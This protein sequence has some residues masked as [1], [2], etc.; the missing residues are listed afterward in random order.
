MN[1]AGINR[2]KFLNSSTRSVASAGA[3]AAVGGDLVRGLANC[4]G[5]DLPQV[6]FP[7]ATDGDLVHEPNWDQYLS[8]TVGPSV[9]SKQAD[10]V[11]NDDKVIQAAIDYVTRLGGGTVR[12]LPGEYILRSSV[13]LPTGLRLLGSGADS[14]LTKIGSQSIGLSEDSDWYDQEITLATDSDFRVGDSVVLRATDPHHGGPIVIKRRLIA[15]NGNR[16]KLNDGLRKNLWHSGK[17]TCASLF[18][19]LTSENVSDVV[20]ENLTLDGNRANNE[21]FNGNHGGC[22]FLQDCSRFVMKN[23]ETR[24]YNGDGISFQICHD[25]VVE[26]CHSHGNAGLGIHPGSGSQRPLIRNNRME[27]NQIGLFWCWGVKY[28]LGEGNQLDANQIGIS[29][30]HNDTDNLMRNNRVA[31]SSKVGIIFRD[32]S[33]GHNFW[34]NRNRLEKNEVIDSGGEEGVAIDIQ[35][36]TRETVLVSNIL[37][38]TRGPAKRIGIRIANEAGAVTLEKNTIEGFAT[39]VL[40]QRSEN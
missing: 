14:V 35:G 32:D 3:L 30:G 4:W 27:G 37:R 6:K 13:F 20:I 1:R 28:G 21:N 24:N 38:E 33:R 17:P 8:I 15:C 40:D 5:A 29:I 7:R 10:L 26:N 25:V 22:I 19:L 23:V 12:L 2:R 11:G 36:K 39:N 9:G 34:P 31:R 16:F 18:P